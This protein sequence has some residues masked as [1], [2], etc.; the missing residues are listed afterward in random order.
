[1]PLSAMKRLINKGLLLTG[2]VP[3]VFEIPGGLPLRVFRHTTFQ[4]HIGYG[5]NHHNHNLDQQTLRIE[6][7][8]QLTGWC[9]AEYQ[10][11]TTSTT[12]AEHV[13]NL[14]IGY[15]TCVIAYSTS[16]KEKRKL[17]K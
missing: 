3:N 7:H 11:G 17:H 14:H 9:N 8:I 15:R 16:M 6:G 12:M 5:S 2:S 4:N 1:M 13:A 10:Y